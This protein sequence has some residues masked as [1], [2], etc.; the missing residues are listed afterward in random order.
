LINQKGAGLLCD[1]NG[2]VSEV[3]FDGIGISKK[4]EDG[5]GLAGLFSPA[6]RLELDS[7]LR[8]V[9]SSGASF[10]RE[11]FCLDREKCLGF[12]LNG[13]KT[14]EGL[15]I[16]VTEARPESEYD[17]LFNEISALNNELVNARR[18]LARKNVELD[19]LASIDPLTGIPNR[20]VI[21]EFASEHFLLAKRYN[22][23]FSLVMIDLDHFKRVNDTYGHQA[24]DVVLKKTGV[25]VERNLRDTDHVGRYGGEE[26]LIVLP[27]TDASQAFQ[28]AE[29]IREDISRE[30]FQAEGGVSFT[31]TVSL[32]VSA[33]DGEDS[34]ETLLGR[35][36]R[37]L[38]R[39]KEN[40][41]NQVH[42]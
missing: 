34:L 5:R 8:E 39:A 22:I 36:D 42:S 18:E 30:V 15:V 31:V 32:G 25:L 1:L 2:R 19:R 41:R 35:A 23:T 9:S 17:E 26:I 6:S 29:R 14:S 33:Y 4:L 38:Y 21:L 13:L 20:R 28:V 40:G 7:F 3:I 11:A 10:N 37:A 12:T 24:G 16:T 27:N